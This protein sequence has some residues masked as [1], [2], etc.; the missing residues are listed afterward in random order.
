M[1]FNH[2]K[3]DLEEMANEEM[4][5]SLDVFLESWERDRREWE[6]R[7]EELKRLEEQEEEERRRHYQAWTDRNS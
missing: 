6:L 2:G 1:I 4:A 3:P 5:E 7:Q